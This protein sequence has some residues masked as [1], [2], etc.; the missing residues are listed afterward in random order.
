MDLVD[1]RPAHELLVDPEHVR[2]HE[3]VQ[4]GLLEL[5]P[6]RPSTLT[7]ISQEQWTKLTAVLAMMAPSER[8]AYW[9]VFGQGLTHRQAAREMRTTKGSL[10]NLLARAEEKIE[11]WRGGAPAQS[12]LPIAGD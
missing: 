10:Y 9:L 7:P 5:W 6:G 2:R 4:E 11:A 1:R 12:I 8:R 3:T